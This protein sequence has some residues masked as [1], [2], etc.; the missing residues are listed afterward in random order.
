M[1]NKPEHT[2]F[3]NTMY[4]L[5][6]LADIYQNE[7]SFKLQVLVFIIL[8]IIAWALH[9]EL[10]YKMILQVSLFLPL[11][12]EIANSAIERTVDLVTSEYHIMAKKA[13]DAGAALVF[14]SFVTLGLIWLFTCMIAF[15]WL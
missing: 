13:K 11:L 6:G 5:N 9:V 3:K 12:A 8:S 4:A 15:G 1:F 2:L 7:R 14:V 10:I